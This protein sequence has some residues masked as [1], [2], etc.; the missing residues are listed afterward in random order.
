[1]IGL[2]SPAKS[3]AAR[4]VTDGRPNGSDRESLMTALARPARAL[5]GGVGRRPEQPGNRTRLEQPSWGRPWAT[6]GRQGMVAQPSGTLAAPDVSE[7]FRTLFAAVTTYSITLPA[8]AR[9]VVRA[10]H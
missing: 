6:S 5:A 1:M 3:W 7:A 2:C 10:P 8:S 9:S 4:I